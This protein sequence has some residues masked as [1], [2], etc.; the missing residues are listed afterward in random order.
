MPNAQIM[1]G[2]FE[3][4]YL[5][6]KKGHIKNLLAL[7][8]ADGHLHE[9]E[10]K[11]LYKIGNRSGLKDRQVKELIESEENYE[12]H[13]PD[14]HDEKMNLLYDLILMIHADEVVEKEEVKFFESVVKKFG[15]KKEMAKWLFDLFEKGV[16]PPPDDW[17][18]I[19]DEALERFVAKN[20]S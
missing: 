1:I 16:P 19:K 17:T 9:K 18:D 4:E 14:S 6:F 2:H 5:S 20:P 13:V 3:H 11:L 15:M 7:A 12:L 10:E 8:K